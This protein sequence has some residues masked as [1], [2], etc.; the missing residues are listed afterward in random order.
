MYI[1]TSSKNRNQ[2][3]GSLIVEVH[4]ANLL[5]V[6]DVVITIARISDN[7]IIAE[8]VTN[9][10]GQTDTIELDAPAVE[11]S[12]TPEFFTPPYSSY[13]IIARKGGFIPVIIEGSQI[14]ADVTSIQPIEM[15]PENPAVDDPFA[16]PNTR[17]D[18]VEAIIIGEPTLYGDYPLKI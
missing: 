15:L 1:H 2:S 7:I 9:V 13:R 3:M 10:V 14:F 4:S 11:L 12:E 18:E 17:A 16:M 5:P 6:P 8:L